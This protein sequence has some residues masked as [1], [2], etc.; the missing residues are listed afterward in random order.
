LGNCTTDNT[1]LPNPPDITSD[2]A[3]LFPEAELMFGTLA[4]ATAASA[5]ALKYF[6]RE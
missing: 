1:T 3:L 5:F 2:G 4:F 6:A